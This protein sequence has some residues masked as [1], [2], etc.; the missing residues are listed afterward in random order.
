MKYIIG[1]DEAGRGPALGQ[2]VLAGVKIPVKD[3]E[4]LKDLNVRDS[5]KYGSQKRGKDKRAEIAKQICKIAQVRVEILSVKDVDDNNINTLEL[6][7]ARKIL[8]SLKGEDSEIFLDGKMLFQPL[9]KEFNN[10]YALDKADELIDAVSAASIV[11]KHF[12]DW[13]WLKIQK[14]YIAEFGEIKGS[15]YG[16]DAIRF[17][18]QYFLKYNIFPCEARTSWKNVKQIKEKML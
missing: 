7:T 16:A 11:A 5:K 13:L 9:Q 1:V 8:Y 15:G 17:I 4:L 2:M 12:R 3:L 6:R 14:K 10:L 18:E